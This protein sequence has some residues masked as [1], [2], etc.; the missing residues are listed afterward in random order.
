MQPGCEEQRL[1][2]RRKNSGM[3]KRVPKGEN[4]LV[5]WL[6][7]ARSRFQF[8]FRTAEGGWKMEAGVWEFSVPDISPLVMN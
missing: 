3:Q 7:T 4:G 5:D 6:Q 1:E 2:S 8:I